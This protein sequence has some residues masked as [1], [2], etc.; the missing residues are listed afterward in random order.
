MAQELTHSQY[1]ARVQ[2]VHSWLHSQAREG[3]KGLRVNGGRDFSRDCE[4]YDGEYTECVWTREYRVTVTGSG[5][6]VVRT[7]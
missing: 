4:L 2:A 5:V 3:L 6:R 1:M 7:R